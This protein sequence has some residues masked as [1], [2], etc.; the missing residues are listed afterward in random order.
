M[1]ANCPPYG[2]GEKV[3]LVWTHMPNEQL[4]ADKTSRI[5]HGRWIWN[6]RKTQQIVA[7]RHQG[8]VPDGCALSKHSGATKNRMEA[9][10]DTCG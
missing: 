4:K 5:W 10:C 1:P 7:R 9:V 3:E 8:M 2:D 6:P